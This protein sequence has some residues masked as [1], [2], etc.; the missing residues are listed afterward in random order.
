M[1]PSSSP[2]DAALL[3]EAAQ[4]HAASLVRHLRQGGQKLVG[5][6]NRAGTEVVLKVVR[7]EN[8]ATDEALHRAEREAELLA[9]MSNPHLVKGLTVAVEH[10]TPPYAISWLEEYLDGEDLRDLVGTPWDPAQTFL[11]ATDVADALAGLH[12]R[13]VVHRDLSAGNVRRLSSGSFKLLDPGFARHLNR[14]G[15]TGLWQPGTPGF[16]SPEHVQTGMV[17]SAASD[18]F[19]LGVLMW[20]TLTSQLPIPAHDLNAYTVALAS[21]QL[22]GIETL[23]PDL[24]P[25]QASIINRCLSRQSARRYFDGTELQVAFGDL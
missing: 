11:M 5:L 12:V 10:G 23:R 3:Q 25:A 18:V 2:S 24:S 17:P 6:V 22:P 20:L 9:S 4:A 15:L 14:S 8:S 19:S 13:G 21:R 1:P 7:V 16:M